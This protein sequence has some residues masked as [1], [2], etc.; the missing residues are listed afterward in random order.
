MGEMLKQG[1]E[2]KQTQKLSPLQ[3]QT[4]KLIE[5]P[6]QDLEMRVRKEL[7][8]NPVLDEETSAETEDPEVQ[9]PR[10]VS[11]Q[12][13]K[14]D[15]SIPTYNLRVN[16]WGP[17]EKK[18]Y[19]TFSVKESFSHSLEEQIGFREM[20]EN[21]RAIAYFIVGSLD[22][23]GYLRRD[24]DSLVDDMAFKGSIHTDE[25]EVLKVLSMIQECEPA[26]VGARDL[27]EC[28]MLQLRTKSQTPAV[29]LAY[30]ILDT[31]FNDFSSKHFKKILSK[32]GINEEQLKEAIKA[33]T[34][35]NPSPGGQIDDSYNDHAKQIT[36]DFVLSYE[37]GEFS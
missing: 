35:L 34:K 4:I 31:Q 30:R 29:R 14:E 26:G 11:L 23:D 20:T 6:L 27:R 16:N 37:N 8:E 1:L 5:L 25:K 24:I 13:F 2:L 36:P 18:G 22:S 12:E 33:I 7:E 10:E 28:L 21:E 15:D 3:M 17:D 19:D 9:G 32:Q